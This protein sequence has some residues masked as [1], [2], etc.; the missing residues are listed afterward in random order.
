MDDQS[1]GILLKIE[2]AIGRLEGGVEAMQTDVKDLRNEVRDYAQK[3]DED[4][5]VINGK[6]RILEDTKSFWA[7]RLG[8]YISIGAVLISAG[9]AVFVAL[10]KR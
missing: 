2:K 10:F 6:V 4:C 7:G 1:V 3:R 5:K 9:T 8:A